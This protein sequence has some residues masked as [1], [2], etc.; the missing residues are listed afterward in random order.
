MKR[1]DPGLLLS[2]AT[3]LVTLLVGCGGGTEEAR[4]LPK[5]RTTPEA[6]S[7]DSNELPGGHPPLGDASTPAISPPP[8][9]S[10][11]GATALQWTAPAAW[12]EQTPVSSMRKAQ[13]RVPGS[14]GD[15][16]LAVFY[17]G[18]GQGGAPMANA[19]RWANQFSPPDGS[20][21]AEPMETSDLEVNGIPMLL[22]ETK[23]TYTNRM[24][25][26]EAFPDYM[27]LAAVA[28]GPDANWF[29]KLTG[30]QTTVE[31]NRDGFNSLV[32]SIQAG[33]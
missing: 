17:F 27:L 3:L 20:P 14:G 13:Y 25:S 24:V 16:E 21:V 18:P 32:R 33:K 23:G 28:E 7:T 6:T 29:F 8:P 19:R 9:A 4:D 31:E 22:I 11:S 2:G 1:I 15:G 30:P 26:E 10:G 5:A 12:D